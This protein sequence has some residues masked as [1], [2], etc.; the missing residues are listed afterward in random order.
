MIPTRRHYWSASDD[1]ML[2]DTYPDA[3]TAEIA[4]LMGL[5]AAQVYNRAFT[6][7]LH[8]SPGFLATEASGRVAR[9]KQHPRMLATQFA[10]GFTPWNK[11]MKGIQIGGVATQFQ[12][13]SLPHTTMAVGSLRICDGMLQRKTNDKPGPNHVRW[14][15]I[16]R[17]V[18]E[19]AHGPLPAGHMVVFKPGMR[20]LILEDITLDRLECISRADNARRNHPRNKHPELAR[21]VQLKGAITRQV[22]RLAR[23][24]QPTTG[25]TAP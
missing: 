3:P 5:R 22:N 9:G 16:T 4:A 2:R 15:P 20:T 13:G 23:E 21:L 6:L 1:A 19:A 14:F 12:P 8:K 24:H 10:K 7:G 25:A 18:W 17:L 11:G